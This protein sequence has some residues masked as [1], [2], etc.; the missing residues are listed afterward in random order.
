M[1]RLNVESDDV[2]AACVV[3]LVG[4]FFAGNVSAGIVR[5]PYQCCDGFSCFES[6]E[7]PQFLRNSCLRPPRGK[8]L[9]ADEFPGHCCPKSSHVS[10]AE[11]F[12]DRFSSEVRAIAAFH[13]IAGGFIEIGWLMS[14]QIQFFT[15]INRFI[16]INFPVFYRTWANFIQCKFPIDMF[17]CRRLKSASS[18]RSAS[19]L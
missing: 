13:V 11:Y 10:C 3:L 1:Q 6:T 15:S 17:K 9:R 5:P 16:S 14:I 8:C 7:S 2:V 12:A 18:A 19:R 4:R